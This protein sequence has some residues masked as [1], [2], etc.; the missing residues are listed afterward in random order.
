MFEDEAQGTRERRP[1]REILEYKEVGLTVSVGGNR[2]ARH[3]RGLWPGGAEGF[4][5]GEGGRDQ[6]PVELN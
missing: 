6:E 4:T 2:I 1:N 3:E 5:R